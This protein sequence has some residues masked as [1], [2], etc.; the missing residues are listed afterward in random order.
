MHKATKT[1]RRASKEPAKYLV[2]VLPEYVKV[3]EAA[4]WVVNAYECHNR[5]ESS[6]LAMMLRELRTAVRA[7]EAARES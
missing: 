4:G 7:A 6:G 5:S 1:P 2:G 3:I